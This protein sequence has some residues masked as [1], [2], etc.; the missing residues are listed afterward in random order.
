MAQTRPRP[1]SSEGRSTDRE[2]GLG[3]HRRGTPQGP[4]Q[5]ELEGLA[6]GKRGRATVTDTDGG[7]RTSTTVASGRHS[8]KQRSLGVRVTRNHPEGLTVKDGCPGKERGRAQERNPSARPGTCRRRGDA[9][10][11]EE[12]STCNS[13]APAPA[14]DP[15]LVTRGQQTPT[16]GTGSLQNKGHQKHTDSPGRGPVARA[17]PHGPKGL[18]FDS[19]PG[20]VSALQ[21]QPQPQP[22]CSGGDR[23]S[24][25]DASLSPPPFRSL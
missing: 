18:G 2:L 8:R 20:H 1:H 11:I 15:N 3:E 16:R 19:D 9:A 14:T 23:G 5:R 4:L 25:V 22:V 12:G 13:T 21:A 6:G 24:H 7:V 10:H 17:W